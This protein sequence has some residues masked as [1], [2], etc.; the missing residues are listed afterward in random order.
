MLA[1]IV[2]I[3]LLT[4]ILLHKRKL[5]HMQ[6]TLHDAK[7]EVREIAQLP[8]NNPYPLIHATQ[9]GRILFANPAAFEKFPDLKNADENHPVLDP[10]RRHSQ[11]GQPLTH[12]LEYKDLI[13]H[14]TIVPTIVDGQTTYI[15]YCYDI[16]ARKHYE[17]HLQH[18]NQTAQ[19]LRVEAEKA[20]QARGDFLANMSH[21]L[22][23][24]MNG[25][26]GLSDILIDTDMHPDHKQL[27]E[28][29]HASSL[30]LLT[31][32]ND[33]LDF[34]KIE[35][36]E[37]TIESIPFNLPALLKN[38]QK[39]QHP[40]AAKKSLTLNFAHDPD[41]PEHLVGD[42]SRLQQILNNLI[43]NALKFTSK[44]TVTVNAKL[45]NTTDKKAIIAFEVSDTGI[46]MTHEEQAKIFQK[47]Q[48]ADTSTA[49][50]YGGT[51]L[52]LAITKNLSHIM[53][54]NITVK[55][56][57]GKGS[58]FTVMLPFEIAKRNTCQIIT[59]PEAQQSLNIKSAARILIV[60]D[61][62]INL[63]FLRA[64]LQSFGLNTLDKAPNG[65]TALNLAKENA[66]DIILMDCQMPDMDGYE[67]TQ[68]IRALDKGKFGPIIIAV[69]ADAMKDAQEKC[70]K[71]GMNDYLSKPVDKNKLKTMLQKYLLDD[72]TPDQT[73]LP[74]PP[75]TKTTNKPVF[76][77]DWQH[78]H[79][80]SNGDD[81]LKAQAVTVFL[82]QA[83]TD[84]KALKNLTSETNHDDWEK[85]THR[86][87][88]SASNLGA[89]EF[90]ALCEEANAL[91]APDNLRK[92][93]YY[94]KLTRS[95]AAMEKTLSPLYDRNRRAVGK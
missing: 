67:T 20:N 8:L 47:F 11:T 22:R 88:G 83:Q 16:T 72:I 89:I 51:G 46:G 80:F 87:Y 85:S 24:P 40:V 14:Q 74:S 53:G 79:D 12:E 10:L 49:R 31:L 48:Q 21:E 6:K 95:Y 36:G 71:A 15:I 43:G 94:E 5:K 23:T 38:I 65:Q 34:S 84:L 18:S 82:E 28:A 63:L 9:N 45:H 29:I 62:P 93:L 61:H 55:S 57:Y 4:I 52:G 1:I 32:L 81:N 70:K 78:L 39:L 50:K 27:I 30:N 77:F 66:Y 17:D 64:C 58:I 90:A 26:I 75:K 76:N 37:L 73:Q 91:S 33:I 60:D 86:L 92:K 25:I 3:A 19:R 44:G 2:C 54:G 68:H 69:T 41:I 59:Q 13:W 42:P 56:E 7:R 35:A